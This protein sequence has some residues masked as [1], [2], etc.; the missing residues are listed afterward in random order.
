RRQDLQTPA[1]QR[2]RRVSRNRRRS[3]RRKK[4]F[5]LAISSSSSQSRIRARV[6]SLIF[7]QYL[8]S[9][10][11]HRSVRRDTPKLFDFLVGQRDAAGSP[12]VPAVKGAD[13]AETILDSVNHDVESGRQAALSS[14]G[15]VLVGRIRDVQREVEAALRIAPIDLVNALRR[16]HVSFLPFWTDGIATER[17]PIRF[18]FLAVGE[19]RQSTRRLFNHD[20]I[21]RGPSRHWIPNLMRIKMKGKDQH[22]TRDQ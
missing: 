16:F 13:P 4:R 9:N 10:F 12:I 1:G 22:D 3:F 15:V 8:R 7:L 20:S 5:S 6:L 21:N 19:D 18:Q 14:S 17:N 11:Y 2:R